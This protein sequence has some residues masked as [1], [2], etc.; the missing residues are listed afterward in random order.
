VTRFEDASGSTVS[1]CFLFF[2]LLRLKLDYFCETFHFFSN[3]FSGIRGVAAL[4][5]TARVMSAAAL[6]RRQSLM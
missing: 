3:L 6:F 1:A 2:L 5:I 4:G